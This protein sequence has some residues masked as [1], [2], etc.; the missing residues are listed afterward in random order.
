LTSKESASA[1]LKGVDE[2][3]G[4]DGKYKGNIWSLLLRIF[5]NN[6]FNS[7]ITPRASNDLPSY[8]PSLSYISVV[9]Q[10]TYS[11]FLEGFL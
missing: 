3:A 8:L 7:Q 10:F 9:Q 11:S 2:L 5:Q 1:R 6:Y 4:D